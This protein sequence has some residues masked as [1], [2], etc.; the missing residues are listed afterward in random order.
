MKKI[1]VFGTILS[2]PMIA[3]A[4]GTAMAA[5]PAPSSGVSDTGT[6][7]GDTVKQA[8]SDARASDTPANAVARTDMPSDAVIGHKVVNAEGDTVGEVSAIAGD[9]VIVEVGGFLGMGT[10]GVALEWGDLK[11]MGSGED[12]TLQTALTKEQIG[13]LPKAGSSAQGAEQTGA[14]SDRT[15]QDT[16]QAGQSSDQTDQSAAQAGM[17]SQKPDMPTKA[18]IGH[19]VVNAESDKVG[20]VSAI[21]GNRVIVKVGG[22]LGIGTHGVALEWNDLKPIGSGED[23][24]LQTT[25]TDEQIGDL[26]KYEQ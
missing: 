12:M 19:K 16:A 14:G 24:T 6:E 21:A 10:H 2:A 9:S 15:N 17:S 18:V 1:T 3:L 25:L 11:S 23:M 5:D 26:P 22:F 20:E 13:D 7:A 4:A 8:T